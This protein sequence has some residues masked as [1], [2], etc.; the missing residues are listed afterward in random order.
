MEPQNSVATFNG[1]LAVALE[2][3]TSK[4]LSFGF[5]MYHSI[6]PLLLKKLRLVPY[7]I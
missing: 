4:Y 2:N 6:L 7:Q 5:L 1:K 3:P